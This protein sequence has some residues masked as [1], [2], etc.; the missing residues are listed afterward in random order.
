MP[1]WA[2]GRLID[3]I[4]FA[5]FLDRSVDRLEHPSLLLVS[6]GNHADDAQRSPIAFVVV[7]NALGQLLFHFMPERLNPLPKLGARKRDHQIASHRQRD[8]FARGDR[9]LMEPG[10]AAIELPY[11]TPGCVLCGD[12]HTCGLKSFNVA[13]DTSGMESTEP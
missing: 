12:R 7:P 2:T 8:Q 13:S 11:P 3:R 4:E 9:D 1:S 6:F 10:I 5:M